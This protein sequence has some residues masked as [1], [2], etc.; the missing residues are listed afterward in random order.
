MVRFTGSNL[1][2]Y[3]KKETFNKFTTIGDPMTRSF[4]EYELET[5]KSGPVLQ[6]VAR[7]AF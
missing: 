5:E 2:N 1:L 6:L 7:Y 4:D 3:R